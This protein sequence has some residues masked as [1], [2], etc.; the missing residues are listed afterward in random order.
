MNQI[1]TYRTKDKQ[2]KVA[3]RFDGKLFGLPNTSWLNYLPQIGRR[4]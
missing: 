3:V 1:E 2:T 4:Y